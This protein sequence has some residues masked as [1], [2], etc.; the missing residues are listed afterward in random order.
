MNEWYSTIYKAFIMTSIISFG[1]YFLTTGSLSSNSLMAGYSTLI[2]GIAMILLILFNRSLDV[3]QTSGINQTFQI[4]VQSGP[5]LLMLLIIVFIMMLLTTYN[6]KISN[7]QVSDGYYVFSN[8]LVALLLVQIIMVYNEIG[9]EKFESTQ[10]MSK[11]TNS[12]I[13]LLSLL[14]GIC[15]LVLF[16]ILRYYT[17]DG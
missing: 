15:T 6:K 9:G 8:M 2:L 10:T 11:I 3:Q 4:M 12:L 17:T 5:F 16:V 1:I 14:T 7:N 13:Y